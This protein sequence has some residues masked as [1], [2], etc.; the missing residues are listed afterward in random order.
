MKPSSILH[1]PLYLAITIQALLAYEWIVSGWTKVTS[2]TFVSTFP[3]T[4]I[5]FTEQNPHTWYVDT[6]LR[7]STQHATTFAEL[8]RWGEL[9]AGLGIV[10]GSILLLQ[11]YTSLHRV[12]TY[13]LVG[14]LVGGC[15]MNANFYFAAGWTSPS[16]GGLNLLMFGVQL[17][18]IS[19]WVA[20]SC[21]GISAK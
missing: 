5:R 21:T 15:W 17:V 4:L 8:V 18:L 16:T 6:I 19:F 13:V 1:H 2:E 3:A 14:A 9:L 10:S 12:G 20:R 11:K 7:F